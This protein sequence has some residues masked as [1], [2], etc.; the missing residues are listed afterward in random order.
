MNTFIPKSTSATPRHGHVIEYPDG[1]V[2]SRH[3]TRAGAESSLKDAQRVH[4][5]H[6]RVRTLSE[7]E[8]RRCA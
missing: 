2:L 6:L 7:Q 1:Y 5:N 8:I 3:A 4:G